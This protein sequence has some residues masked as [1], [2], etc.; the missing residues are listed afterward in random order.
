MFDLMGEPRRALLLD[1]LL[2]KIG[3]FCF[4]VGGGVS[5]CNCTPWKSTNTN[6]HT[7]TGTEARIKRT[8]RRRLLLFTDVLLVA[9]PPLEPGNDRERVFVKQ[10][11]GGVGCSVMVG[12]DWGGRVDRSLGPKR[13]GIHPYT[14]TNSQNQQ[15]QNHQK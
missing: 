1:G 7:S 11:C 10:V 2:D 6:T 13:K 3:A 8:N 4:G 5:M 14:N 15:P 9:E 12:E